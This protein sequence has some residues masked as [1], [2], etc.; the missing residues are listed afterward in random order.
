MAKRCD[1][2]TGRRAVWDEAHWIASRRNLKYPEKLSYRQAFKKKA[3]TIIYPFILSTTA[4]IEAYWK[5]VEIII[6]TC[7]SVSMITSLRPRQDGRYFKRHFLTH[8]L[9]EN[10]FRLRF[11]WNLFNTSILELQQ[12]NHWSLGIYKWFNST[13]HNGRNYYPMLH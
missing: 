10:F 4:V 11:H 6:I 13:F 2:R 9:N 7:Q 8:F 1:R 12:S 5:Y 3:F